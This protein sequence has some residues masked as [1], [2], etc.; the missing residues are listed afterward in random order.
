MGNHLNL[1]EIHATAI[2]NKLDKSYD[3]DQLSVWRGRERNGEGEMV[4][5][6]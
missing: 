1:E 2:I 4:N 5:E 6:P 3:T